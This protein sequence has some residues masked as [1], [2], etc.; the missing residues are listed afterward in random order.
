MPYLQ[1]SFVWAVS[2]AGDGAVF[3]EQINTERALQVAAEPLTGPR[4]SLRRWLFF[5]AGHKQVM[6]KAT[7]NLATLVG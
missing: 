3:D 5:R 7:A 4:P 6:A 1:G 2:D